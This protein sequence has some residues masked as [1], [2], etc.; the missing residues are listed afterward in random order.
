MCVS[1]DRERERERERERALKIEIEKLYINQNCIPTKLGQVPFLLF[2]K[3][4]WNV[5]EL[6]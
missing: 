2:T 4:A 6:V 5:H 3:L 1:Q